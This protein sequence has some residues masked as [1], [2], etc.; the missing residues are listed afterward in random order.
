VPRA[1]RDE[2]MKLAKRQGIRESD[3]IR[4][5]IRR[6]LGIGKLKARAQGVQA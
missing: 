4:D 5:F 3:V 1:W 6:G 2:I